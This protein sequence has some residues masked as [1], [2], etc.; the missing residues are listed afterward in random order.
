MKVIK[1][2]NEYLFSKKSVQVKPEFN[3]L[4]YL[5]SN[6]L[7]IS[8][9]HAYLS[10]YIYSL[11]SN[12]YVIHPEML[13]GDY[14]DNKTKVSVYLQDFQKAYPMVDI[15]I[16]KDDD[17]EF[18]FTMGY[19]GLTSEVKCQHQDQPVKVPDN[20]DRDVAYGEI[21]KLKAAR[22]YITDVHL[23]EYLGINLKTLNSIYSG[24]TSITG[25]VTFKALDTLFQ[26]TPGNNESVYDNIGNIDLR[27]VPTWMSRQNGSSKEVDDRV[28]GIFG[29][30]GNATEHPTL[31]KYSSLIASWEDKLGYPASVVIKEVCDHLIKRYGDGFSPEFLLPPM[32][33]RLFPEVTFKTIIRYDLTT[34]LYVS[35]K[36][37][38]MVLNIAR[39]NA[40]IKYRHVSKDMEGVVQEDP[41]QNTD[42]SII[43]PLS[44]FESLIE[45][46]WK[47]SRYQ[48]CTLAEKAEAIVSKHK[49]RTVESIT[50][51]LDYFSSLVDIASEHGYP[52]AGDGYDLIR[53]R[54]SDNKAG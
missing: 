6:G 8:E 36:G 19:K 42:E 51:P 1:M 28:P 24:E 26:N 13:Y 30:D 49:E 44:M 27:R 34:D 5:E 9:I 20:K 47:L 2:I 43:V 17:V 16:I 18:I 54:E 14:G 3:E 11:S 35:Y 23:A 50:I 38:R 4:E 31:P 22:A 21:L 32:S 29:C 25:I 53:D 48:N 12:F 37:S 33:E 10:K 46:A 52:M 7:S 15:T 41:V 40:S 39:Q 45:D